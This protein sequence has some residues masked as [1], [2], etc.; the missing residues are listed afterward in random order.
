MTKV[1]RVEKHGWMHHVA[2][3]A[4]WGVFAGF[5]ALA[6]LFFGVSAYCYWVLPHREEATFLTLYHIGMGLQHYRSIAFGYSVV[7]LIHAILLLQMTFTSI[8]R[9]RFVFIWS[10]PISVGASADP[11]RGIVHVLRRLLWLVYESLFAPT[12]F[13]GVNGPCFDLLLLLREV[14]ETALQTN[15][16]YRMSQFLARAW[17]NQFYVSLLVVNC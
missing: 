14:V 12:G 13:F 2:V 8:R 17:F 3:V 1:T 16:A 7:A 5:H 9:R 4:A 15:Q 10:A 6:L 11:K